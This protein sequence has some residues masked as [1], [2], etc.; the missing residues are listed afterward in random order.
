MAILVRV[1]VRIR[2]RTAVVYRVRSVAQGHPAIGAIRGRGVRWRPRRV[3][4]ATDR[5]GTRVH[6]RA[7]RWGVRVCACRTRAPPPSIRSDPTPRVDEGPDNV[8]IDPSPATGR[9]VGMDVT[10]VVAS[11]D[12]V[13]VHLGVAVGVCVAVVGVIVNVLTA[14]VATAAVLHIAG[15]GAIVALVSIDNHRAVRPPLGPLLLLRLLLGVM[16]TRPTRR[17][18]HG[19]LRATAHGRRAAAGGGLRATV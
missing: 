6:A 7:P 14:S 3:F 13:P 1:R 15:G 5:V 16:C 17:R 4:A 11:T 19:G 2:G 12:A 8:V 9:V 18:V 10:G